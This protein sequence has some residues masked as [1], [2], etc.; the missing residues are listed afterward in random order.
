MLA[1][2]S[3]SQTSPINLSEPHANTDFLD[4]PCTPVAPTTPAATEAFETPAAT[5][6]EEDAAE[7]PPSAHDDAEKK[8]DRP[9]RTRKSSAIMNVSEFPTNFKRGK[10]EEEE[11]QRKM[12]EIC[13][14]S[15]KKK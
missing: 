13:K 12:G 4:I 3:R 10:M 7:H 2:A 8:Q 9:K 15:L 6:T 5:L 11:S 14:R 1:A